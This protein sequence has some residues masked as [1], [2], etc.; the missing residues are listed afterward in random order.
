MAS[1]CWTV[2]S[3]LLQFQK[4]HGDGVTADIVLPVAFA[5]Q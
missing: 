3:L 5:S 1:T 4:S 2:S